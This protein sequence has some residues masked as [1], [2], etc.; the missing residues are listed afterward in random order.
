MKAKKILINRKTEEAENK[1][2]SWFS[3]Q[4]SEALKETDKSLLITIAEAKQERSLMQNRLS[5]L[6]YK[7]LAGQGDMKAEEYRAHC[8]LHL[9]VPLLRAECDKFRQQYD[10]IIRP[11]EYAQKLSIMM[12]PIDMP[13]T[14]LMSVS[15]FS[16]YLK[17]VEQYWIEKGFSLS[18]PEDLYYKAIN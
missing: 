14:S 15:V 7:E 13:V 6:W 17:Q 11:L 9:G 8:K 10:A 3:Q 2:F 4:I 1:G 18:R 12:L 16:E 5:F